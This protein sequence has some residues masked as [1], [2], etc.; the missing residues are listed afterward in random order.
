MNKYKIKANEETL[1]ASISNKYNPILTINSGDSIELNT[2]DVGWGFT[3]K[4]GRR[5]R[6]NSREKESEWGHPIIGPIAIHGAKQGMTLEVKVNDIIPSWYG[7]TCAGGYSNWHNRQLGLEK[8]N[9]VVFD[10]ELDYNNNLGTCNYQDHC[11]QVTLSPFMG[12]MSV[13]PKEEGIHSTMPPR[14]CGGNIDCK[15]LVKGSTLYLPISVDGALFSIGDGH[16]AQGDGEVSGQAIE[17]PMDKV[18][19]LI[20]LREDLNIK[21]PRA[22]TPNGWIT[23]GF[24]EDLN[25]AMIIAL[26]GMLELLQDEY[27]LEKAEATALASVVVDLRVTQIVNEVKG[28]HAVLGHDKITHMNQSEK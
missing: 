2:I 17:C 8:S 18:E 13:A 28:V 27:G 22:N 21:M 1:H 9:E 3:E 20:R 16:A 5:I 23:F 14:Y 24:H 10:W 25:Q 12:F 6:F 15:E 11:F 7:W 19:L 26:E 4:N